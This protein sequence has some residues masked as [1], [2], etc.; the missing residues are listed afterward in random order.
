MEDPVDL[1]GPS[2]MPFRL[3]QEKLLLLLLLSDTEQAVTVGRYIIVC[4]QVIEQSNFINKAVLAWRR[5][6]AAD[7]IIALF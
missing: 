1:T 6:A 3:R 5:K 2:I 7:R 4:L